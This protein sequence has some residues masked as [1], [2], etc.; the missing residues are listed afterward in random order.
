[1]VSRD[2]SMLAMVQEFAAVATEDREQIVNLPLSQTV[3]AVSQDMMQLEILRILRDMQH[4][5][6]HNFPADHNGDGNGGGGCRGQQRK[7][8]RKTPDDASFDHQTTGKHC[9]KHS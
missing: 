4:D 9:W 2:T 1:M 5:M 8:N 6:Q 3:N 7:R